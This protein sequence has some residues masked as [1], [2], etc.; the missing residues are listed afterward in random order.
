MT[1][2]AGLVDP[3]EMEEKDTKRCNT[4]SIV[5]IVI[6][7]ILF[8]LL[9]VFIILYN[10]AK[11]KSD[12]SSCTVKNP[13]DPS[14]F[15]PV[16]ESVYSSGIDGA[17]ALQGKHDHIDS[18]YFK[19]PDIY[20]MKSTETRKILPHFKTAQQTSSY[21]CGCTTMEM[22]LNYYGNNKFTERKCMIAMGIEDP[23]NRTYENDMI[24]FMA[25]FYMN[26]TNAVLRSLGYSTTSNADFT[27]ETM[28]FNDELSFS[29]WVAKTIEN[30][31]AIIVHTADWAAHYLTIIGVDNMGTP[32][33]SGD[34]VLILADP[35]DTTD[36]LQDGY[37]IWGLERFYA[38]WQYTH[39]INIRDE[40][41]TH[42][43]FIVVHHK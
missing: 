31:D 18:E 28:P 14:Q 20:N 39:I 35:F 11:G 17:R 2:N 34:D 16:I 42:S 24:Y 10:G 29:K 23:D 13:L 3:I 7:V 30:G 36:H 38:M 43:Q 33:Y 27:E 4:I 21:S 37:N 6:D 5:A 19:I 26:N 32:D 8:I 12:S 1:T 22:V 40:E 9:I 15:L 25:L 41:Y